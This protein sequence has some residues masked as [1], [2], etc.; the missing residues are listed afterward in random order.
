M[1]PLYCLS[2]SR[3][4]RASA[5]NSP[6]TTTPEDVSTAGDETSR[7]RNAENGGCRDFGRRGCPSV[8]ISI[9][10]TYGQ[11]SSS[12]E[13]FNETPLKHH[14]YGVM[15]SMHDYYPR[16]PSFDSRLYPRNFSGNI[17]SRTWSIQLRED[18][19]AAT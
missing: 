4:Q 13:L 1:K 2:I 12:T 18:N 7:G 14:V 15:I 5:A 3:I 19:W 9:Y 16:G 6:G 11:R 8:R 17:V 10:S